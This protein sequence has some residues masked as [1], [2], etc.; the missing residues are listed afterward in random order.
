MKKNGFTL[1]ELLVVIAIIAI[2]A[3]M[4]LPALSKA[5]DK[6]S[7]ANCVS[8][9]KQV[10][11]AMQMYC[12][13]HDDYVPGFL[14]FYNATEG[15]YYVNRWIAVLL[16]Y[17]GNAAMFMCP[18]SKLGGEMQMRNIT[19]ITSANWYGIYV[20]NLNKYQTTGINGSGG[21]LSSFAFGYTS[22]KLISLRYPS[23]LIYAGGTIDY[24]AGNYEDGLF[25]EAKV[26]PEG[27]RT[28]RAYHNNEKSVNLIQCDGS[29]GTYP[30][31]TVRSW[32]STNVSIEGTE[33]WK[34]FKAAR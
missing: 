19:S 24:N 22:H 27:G 8:R 5:R 29:V 10:G 11:L 9:Q 34:R 18:A 33:G 21:A 4:L 28:I 25:F 6:A 17:A 1:I 15:V 2:L 14:G 16:P 30:A 12:G 20:N 26:Y 7:T 13:D 3:S 23:L 31:N 32:I